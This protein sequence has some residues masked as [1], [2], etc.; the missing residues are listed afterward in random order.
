MKDTQLFSVNLNI[1]KTRDGR[2][3]LY[4]VNRIHKI[5]KIGQASLLSETAEKSNLTGSPYSDSSDIVP[6]SPEI[7]KDE[8]KK[9]LPETDSKGN[10]LTE[11]QR[12]F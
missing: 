8:S 4:D 9:S 2:N 7:V 11:Q 5:K 12:V 3:V 10:K 6:Q 1:A